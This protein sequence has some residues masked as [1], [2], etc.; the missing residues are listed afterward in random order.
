MDPRLHNIN[1]H[2]RDTRLA[3]AVDLLHQRMARPQIPAP[4][5]AVIQIPRLIRINQRHTERTGATP[6]NDPPE[7]NAKHLMAAP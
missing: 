5:I 4:V 6:S 1:H 2:C 3:F 7:L